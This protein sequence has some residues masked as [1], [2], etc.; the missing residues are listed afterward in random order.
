M[1]DTEDATSIAAHL[2]FLMNEYNKLRPNWEA[3]FNSMKMSAAAR[4]IATKNALTSAILRECPYIT[5]PKLV[6]WH[7]VTVNI[8]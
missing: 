3:M 2:E 1:D 7:V 4:E 6:S 5:I 8:I